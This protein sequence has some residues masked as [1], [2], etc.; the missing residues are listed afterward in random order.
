MNP[1][2]QIIPI[3]KS[4]IVSGSP[5]VIFFGCLVAQKNLDIF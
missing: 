5:Y 3:L 4:L 2:K 1:F